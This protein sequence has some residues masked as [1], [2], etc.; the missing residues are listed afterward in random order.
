MDKKKYIGCETTHQFFATKRE[1]KGSLSKEK[2]A[3]AGDAAKKSFTEFA[4]F[5][6]KIRS[7][8][9]DTKG[10]RIAP[11]N[12]S[13]DEA[14]KIFYGAESTFEFL[15]L[16]GVNPETDTLETMG[17]KLTGSNTFSLEPNKVLDMM[18]AQ[19]SHTSYS[20]QRGDYS[21]EFTFLLPQV[22]LDAIYL[23]YT[24]S[25]MHLNWIIRTQNTNGQD[26]AT[27]PYILMENNPVSVTAEGADTKLASVKIK[28][29]RPKTQKLMGGIEMTYEV[30]RSTTLINLADTLSYV[31]EQMAIKADAMAMKV[32]INGD[33][34]DNSE[35]APVI[36]VG[37]AGQFKA[38]DIKKVIAQMSR[39]TYSANRMI[40]GLDTGMDIDE[41]P[42]FAGYSGE[43]KQFRLPPL[44]VPSD[45]T[46][47][48]FTMPSANQALFID[49]GRAM[50]K[51]QE[52]GVIIEQER[53]IKN[54]TVIGV[55]SMVVGFGISRRNA[56]VI[57]DKSVDF[58]DDGFPSYMDV[59]TYVAEFYTD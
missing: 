44:G 21:P 11:F 22:I 8:Y 45:F 47:E 17:R 59:D 52:T 26:G 48:I 12:I 55:V 38:K 53:N 3:E 19:S 34:A 31:G 51:L 37:T 57:L 50:V 58:A 23:G 9:E 35:S 49:P 33:L 13:T 16:F 28:Q 2:V 32:L 29:K 5:V 39:L 36:G 30:L 46:R 10:N 20:T 56:R 41:L 18:G 14:L 4:D 6:Y 40:T 25:G 42:E 43:T 1:K 27:F 7:G 24:N 15:Q 54:Q